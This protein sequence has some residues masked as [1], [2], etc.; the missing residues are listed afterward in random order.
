MHHLK[1]CL[2]RENNK[3][4]SRHQ[5]R[6]IGGLNAARQENTSKPLLMAKKRG[7]HPGMRKKG[8]TRNETKPPRGAAEERAGGEENELIC[9]L[10]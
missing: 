8:E 10:G 2:Y 4:K 1:V 3:G 5:K 6:E 9:Q 7:N